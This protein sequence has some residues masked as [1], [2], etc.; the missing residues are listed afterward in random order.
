MQVWMIARARATIGGPSFESRTPCSA[1]S[2]Q[3]WTTLSP[4][5]NASSGSPLNTGV[6]AARAPHLRAVRRVIRSGARSLMIAL[7]SLVDGYL[8]LEQNLVER[9]PRD[10][11]RGR[12]T[13]ATS[14]R[15]ESEG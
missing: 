14:L 3:G 15:H 1:A 13:W 7:Q 10:R 8:T 2:F 9:R 12:R 6:A 11:E 4:E 5:A